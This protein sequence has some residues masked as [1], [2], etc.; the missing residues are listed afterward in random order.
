MPVVNTIGISSLRDN[1]F[2]ISV[3]APLLV[4]IDVNNLTL[5]ITWKQAEW[6]FLIFSHKKSPSI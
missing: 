2:L 1:N 5:Q 4:K 3:N 6:V